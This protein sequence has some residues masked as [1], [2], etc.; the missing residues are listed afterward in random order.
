M[1]PVQLIPKLSV[2]P[3]IERSFQII[4]T[5]SRD[6]AGAANLGPAEDVLIERTPK[7]VG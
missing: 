7:N 2:E 3:P 6:V 5:C 1:E 4:S